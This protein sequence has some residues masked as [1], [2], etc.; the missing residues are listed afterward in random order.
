MGNC[1]VFQS[2]VPNE[3]LTPCDMTMNCFKEPLISH[4]LCP[5]LYLS[6]FENDFINN[7]SN[8]CMSFRKAQTIPVDYKMGYSETKT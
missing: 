5:A 3:L 4:N 2:A 7:N 6:A 1:G 8:N